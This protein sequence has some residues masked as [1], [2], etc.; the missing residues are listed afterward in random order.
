MEA[1]TSP[2]LHLMYSC[3]L[4]LTASNDVET[5]PGPSPGILQGTAMVNMES[6]KTPKLLHTCTPVHMQSYT[7]AHLTLELLYTCTPV[8][9]HSC[10]PALLYT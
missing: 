4:A 1:T 2:A 6:L 5:N 9:M 10:T 8:L 3:Q 7:L